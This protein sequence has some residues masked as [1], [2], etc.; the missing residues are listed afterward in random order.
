[1][2]FDPD[3]IKL[4]GILK[5]AG[6]K[7]LSELTVGEARFFYRQKTEFFGGGA[8]HMAEV[9]DLMASGPE[10]QIPL[11]LYRLEGVPDTRPALIYV[12]GGGWVIGDFETHDKVCRAIAAQ[13]PCRV[14]AI[15]Y[16]LAPEHPF[17]A[18]LNDVLAAVSW[19]AKN[20]SPLGIDADRLA[21]GGDSAGGNICAA[22]C[23]H[24]RDNGP[25]LC[26]Q[27][28]VYP[29]TD[30]TPESVSWPSRIENAE[31]PPLN[32]AAIAWFSSKYLPDGTYDPHDWRLSPLREPDVTRLP[33]AFV[34]TAE[35]DPLRDEG[36]AYADRLAASGVPV[37]YRPFPGLIH[38][39]IEYGGLIGA[40]NRAIAEI[41]EFVRSH[42]S[43]TDQ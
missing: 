9:R 38:G 16:R 28:L 7:P 20:A 14:I 24:A 21:I 12:H 42:T 41:A 33:P 15:N 22:V 5:A 35:Y 30:R 25:K 39:F 8:A 43:F 40:A 29:S 18:G 27:I 23:I 37:V 32:A 6:V 31:V 36:K 34:L 26:A 3:V 13:T 17:P 4:F 10:G 19:I 1:M 11:R 2:N